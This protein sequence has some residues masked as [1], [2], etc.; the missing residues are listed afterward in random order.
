M[1]MMLGGGK[2]KA[3]INMTPM[4]DVL[5]VLIIIFLVISPTM[6]RGLHTLVPQSADTT[7]PEPAEPAHD[8]VV[9]V[10]AD[11]SVLLN[12]EPLDLPTL[13]ARLIRLYRTGPNEVLFIRGE[14]GLEFGKV[15]AVID[16]ARGAGVIR[17]G[18]MTS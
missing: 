16:M 8:I 15:A 6:S 14:R 10:R 5:L 2:T 13:E 4:I 18:L 12:Q 3:D 7:Q 11:G 9:T 1:A 17:V